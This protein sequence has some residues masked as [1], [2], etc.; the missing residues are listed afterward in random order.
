MDFKTL[1]VIM[2]IAIAFVSAADLSVTSNIASATSPVD[3]SEAT[4]LYAR[5]K[6][7]F[8]GG[9]FSGAS[10]NAGSSSFGGGGYPGFGGGFGG[11]SSFASAQSGSNS[12]GK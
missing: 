10:A 5:S 12:F 9:G 1:I 8:F 3:S 6:R 11:A 4:G 7:Q 2:A